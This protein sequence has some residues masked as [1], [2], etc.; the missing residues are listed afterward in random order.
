MATPQ[1]QT[2]NGAPRPGAPPPREPRRGALGHFSRLIVGFVILAILA[3]ILVVNNMPKGIALVVGS[4]APQDFLAPRTAAD[5]YATEQARERAAATVPDY[6]RFDATLAASAGARIDKLA[7]DINALLGDSSLSGSALETAIAAH[8]AGD[9]AFDIAA[10][11]VDMGVQGWSQVATQ[12]REVVVSRMG[13]EVDDQ[14]VSEAR[15]SAA[16]EIRR[17]GLSGPLT[18]ALVAISTKEIQPTVVLDVEETNRRRSAAMDAVEPVMILQ[19]QIIA[20]RGDVLDGHQISLMQDFGMLRAQLDPMIIAGSL[21]LA[22]IL[23]AGMSVY[24]YLYERDTFDNASRLLLVAVV[25]ALVLVATQLSRGLSGYLA[26]VAAGTMLIA[27]LLAP[28]LALFVGPMLSIAVGLILGGEVRFLV[29]ALAGGLIGVFSLTLVGQRSD[30]TRAGLLVG[31]GNV[32]VVLAFALIRGEP[33]STL[34]AWRDMGFAFVNGIIS[35]VLTIGTL[36]FFESTFGILT[37]VRL[38][39][40]ANPNQ[41]LLR[42][43]LVEAPGTY[44]H[45][46]VVGNLAEAA[47]DVVGANPLLARVGAYYHDIGKVV[48]PYF[49]IEN[50]IGQE[51]PH[52]KISPSLSAL[53]ITSHVK[54]GVTL[55]EEAHLPPRIVN[56]IRSHH[57]RTLV[58]F[59]YRRAAEDGKTEQLDEEDYRYDGPLPQTPEEAI[60]MLADAVEAAVRAMP[61]P[62]PPRIEALVKQLIRERLVDGQLAKCDLTLRDLDRIGETF[63]RVLMGIFHARIEYPQ[64][65]DDLIRQIHES[66]IDEDSPKPPEP[67][68]E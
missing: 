18:D 56:F 1:P 54:D 59:F 24:L 34:G 37:A 36:P 58:S 49:F 47:A 33:L 65:K 48:R 3:A 61:E 20:R 25:V 52:D 53:I 46:I 60:V 40:L 23:V 39:E 51:N 27:S 14:A 13:V 9:T 11:I 67:E 41:P 44:H 21:L 15:K 2:V 8:F 68:V 5:S 66:G 62:T 7:S 32:V 12:V 17:M 30:L 6:Y 19:D 4:V 42:R 22:V 55:A 35:A 50:Q 64:N 31:F 10:A 26:P 38:L 16:T 28:R 57:G 43:L 45:S 63:L 29:V